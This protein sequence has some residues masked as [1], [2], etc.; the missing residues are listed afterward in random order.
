MKPADFQGA[1]CSVLL[2]KRS[3]LL[4]VCTKWVMGGFKSYLKKLCT[5]AAWLNKLL[6][7]KKLIR[8]F[9]LCI[10]SRGNFCTPVIPKWG[11]IWGKM[12]GYIFLYSLKLPF[13][14]GELNSILEISCNSERA[15][16]PTGRSV[17]PKALIS[18]RKHFLHQKSKQLYK[19]NKFTGNVSGLRKEDVLAQTLC[20]SSFRLLTYSYTI[21]ITAAPI[22]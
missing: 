22:Y 7:W 12:E 17:N 21:V 8:S 9:H 2:Y 14:S 10:E 11:T 3:S 5:A 16:G 19:W 13:A 1:S 15:E 6:V 18:N 20:G 4:K